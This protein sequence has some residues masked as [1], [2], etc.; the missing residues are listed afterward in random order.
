MWAKEKTFP[1]IK[2]ALG[3]D[4]DVSLR[5]EEEMGPRRIHFMGRICVPKDGEGDG[6]RKNTFLGK[7][8]VPKDGGG[9]G[10]RKDTFPGNNM[11]P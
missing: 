5:M 2:W 8:C 1:R 11:C 4:E 6:A 7:K 10:A 9:D 3:G